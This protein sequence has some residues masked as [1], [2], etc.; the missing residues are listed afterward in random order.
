MFFSFILFLLKGVKIFESLRV[1]HIVS[2]QLQNYVGEVV[3]H[4][5][6]F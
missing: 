6:N 2:V 5:Y 4:N 3:I 1:V